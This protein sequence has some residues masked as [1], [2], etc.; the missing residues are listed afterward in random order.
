MSTP[1]SNTQYIQEIQ[2]VIDPLL[3]TN[4]FVVW[5]CSNDFLQIKEIFNFHRYL[6]ISIFSNLSFTGRSQMQHVEIIF[7]KI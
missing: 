3:F 5:L 4:I 2:E 6:K 1:P 7:Q